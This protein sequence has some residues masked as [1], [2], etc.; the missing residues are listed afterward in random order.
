[1]HIGGDDGRSELRERSH[2]RKVANV[3]P[4]EVGGDVMGDPGAVMR[5]RLQSTRSGRVVRGPLRGA[6]GDGPD[7]LLVRGWTSGT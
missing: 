5:A 1:M 3:W 7:G 4:I 2:V 6:G